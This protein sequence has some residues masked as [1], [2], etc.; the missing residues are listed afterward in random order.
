[1]MLEESS[2]QTQWKTAKVMATFPG[3]DGLVR[4]AE[5]MVKT[6]VFPTYYGKTSKRLDPRDLTVKTSTY[7]RPV[8]KLAPLLAASATDAL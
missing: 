7:K 6:T 3:K 4:T 8:T 5:V 1:M 2:L